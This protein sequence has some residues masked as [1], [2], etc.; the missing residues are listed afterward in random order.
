MTRWRAAVVLFAVCA[1]VQGCTCKKRSTDDDDITGKL[2]ADT[3]FRPS[4]NGFEF[5]NRGGQY[6]S[7]PPVLTTAGVAKLF[8]GGA[9]LGGNA[10]NCKLTPAATEWMQMIN[11]AMNGGQCEGMAVSSLAFFK[12]VNDPATYSPGA[13]TAHDLEYDKVGSLI[14]YYWAFQAVNPVKDAQAKS[15]MQTPNVVEDTLAAMM[16]RGEL[17]TIAIRSTH[18][19]HAVTPYAIEDKGNN[20]H[21]IRIYDNNWPDMSRHIIIDRRANTWKYE[22]ASLN[23]DVPKEPWAGTAQTHTIAVIPLATRLGRGE[24]PF[25][26]GSKRKAVRAHGANSVLITNQ[27]GKRIGR[28]GDTVVNE[29]P[30]AEVVDLDGYMNGGEPNHPMY[31]VPADADYEI[32]IHGHEH[33][34]AQ[35]PDEDHGVSV[36]GNGSAVATETP[37]LK[38]G[39]HDTLSVQRDGGV[40]YSS[41]NGGTIPPIRLAHDGDGTHGMVARVANMKAGAHEPVEYRVDPKQGHV[42]VAGGGKRSESYDLKVTHVHGGAEDHTVEQRGIKYTPGEPHTVHSDPTPGA[43]HTSFTVNKGTEK[44]QEA[45]PKEP[46]TH[47]GKA[48]AHTPKPT[49]K[50]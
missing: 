7:T 3:G 25:C 30:D 29:I 49:P 26:T 28:D 27:D 31:V 18:G 13:T 41:G 45:K 38:G 40:K 14:G 8:G 33:G 36:I 16:R 43:K 32:A 9:C 37:R 21:W 20:I 39:E 47:G 23:P 1:V 6:P 4:K 22:L 48:P 10:Q 11:R 35:H 42:T 2:V 50:R 24:C 15:L 19:G 12:K 46:A 44:A 34:G 5:Q 17:A